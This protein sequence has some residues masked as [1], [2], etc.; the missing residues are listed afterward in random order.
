[1]IEANLFCNDLIMFKLRKFL[2]KFLALYF[3]SRVLIIIIFISPTNFYYPFKSLFIPEH[4]LF[5][6]SSSKYIQFARLSN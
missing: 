1:M 6:K 3:G 2:S 5:I 4:L